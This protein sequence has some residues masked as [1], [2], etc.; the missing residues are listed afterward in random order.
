MA[1][2]TEHPPVTVA[3]TKS[4]VH[5]LHPALS[6]PVTPQKNCVVILEPY[7]RPAIPR[8]EPEEQKHINQAT[9]LHFAV[10]TASHQ[11]STALPREAA[12][13]C[14]RRSAALEASPAKPIPAK[15]REGHRGEGGSSAENVRHCWES[16][17]NV[18]QR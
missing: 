3:P 18:A 14:P 4:E 13:L 17:R 2:T 11:A 1:A 8:A 7:P 15:P 5:G 9:K 12:K 6:P 16:S 10:L